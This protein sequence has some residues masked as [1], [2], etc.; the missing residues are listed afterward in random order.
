MENASKAL[1]IAGG[2][3]IGIV[4]LTVFA[5]MFGSGINFAKNYEDNINVTI[6][7]QFNAQFEKYMVFEDY[8]LSE[9]LTIYDIVTVINLAKEQNRIANYQVIKDVQVDNISFIDKTEEEL[10]QL[11]KTDKKKYTCKAIEYDEYTGKV[12]LIKFQFVPT[13]E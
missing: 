8:K 7:A 6:T 1:M 5:Y 13:K 10:I 11:I 4:I 9:A 12:N 3:L 2:I